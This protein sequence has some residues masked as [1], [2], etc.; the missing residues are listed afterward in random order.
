[1][2][3]TPAIGYGCH[4]SDINEVTDYDP[5]EESGAAAGVIKGDEEIGEGMVGGSTYGAENLEDDEDGETDEDVES[6]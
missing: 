5:D 1:M 6:A 2:L 3:R 4:M